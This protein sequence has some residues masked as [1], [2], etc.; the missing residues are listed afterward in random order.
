MKASDAP[1]SSQS[2]P[3]QTVQAQGGSDVAQLRL[4]VLQATRHRLVIYQP[5]LRD[6]LYAGTAELEQ[7][8]RIAI[9]GRGASIRVIL[10]DPDGALRDNH[11][12][13]SLAQRLSSVVQIRVPVEEQD[14]AYGSAYLLNDQGG[15]VF[16][17]EADASYAR[18]SLDDRAAQ[19]PLAQHFERVWDRAERATVLLPLDI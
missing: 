15:Y 2:P 10:H 9:A 7:L 19:R 5:V 14:L 18:G 16:Q 1:G 3:P 12:L 6:D 13:I 11:R 17:P 8:R 4:Q